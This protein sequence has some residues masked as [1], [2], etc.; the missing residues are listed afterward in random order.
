V[1]YQKKLETECILKNPVIK[2]DENEHNQL[3]ILK[4]RW[5]KK[6]YSEKKWIQKNRKVVL[7]IELDMVIRMIQAVA[8]K[9]LVEEL[10]A[11]KTKGGLHLPD[12][13]SQPQSY[14]KVVSYGENVQNIKVGD[15]LVYHPRAGM[16]LL[17]D[18]KLLK[19][20]KYEELYGI[21]ESEEIKK[22]LEA[23]MFGGHT[24]GQSIIQAARPSVII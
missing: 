3:E 17:V 19:V 2:K 21:L 7:S 4:E 12:N 16:D 14:G 5:K 10:R 18:K 20:L 11:T 22:T 24:E 15:V 1:A 23:V 6:K 8:D 13:T 9:I